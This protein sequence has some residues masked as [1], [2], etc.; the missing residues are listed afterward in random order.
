MRWTG[1]SGGR[2]GKFGKLA[3]FFE[4]D[5]GRGLASERHFG[6]GLRESEAKREDA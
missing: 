3:T 2:R 6:G 1:S 4:D 5:D